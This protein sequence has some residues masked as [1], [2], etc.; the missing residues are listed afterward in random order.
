[1]VPYVIRN[2]RGGISD[3]NDRGIEGSFKHGHSLDIHGRDN[4]IRAASAVAT[5]LD[6]TTGETGAGSSTRGT[7]ITSHFNVFVPSYDG[8]TYAFG[9]TGSIMARSGDGFWTNVYNDTESITGA[10]EFGDSSGAIYMYWGKS[11]SI[12][13]RQMGGTF[14]TARDSGQ[15]RWSNATQV[16]KTEY[17]QST[18][19]WHTMSMASG[20]L[21]MANG[22][23][24]AVID[25][26]GNFNPLKLNIRPGNIINCLE[27]RDDNIILGSERLDESEEGH[28]WSWVVTALNWVQK[29]KIPVQGINALINT[30]DRLLQGGNNG[31]IFYSDFIN[32][33]PVATIP[34]GGKVI[35]SGVAIHE[36]LAAFGFSGGTYPGIWT[37][38]RRHKNRSPAFN[39]QYRLI[40][41]VNGSTVATIGAVAVINGTLLA[42]W[43]IN[44]TDSSS[45]GIDAVSATSRATALFEGLEFDKGGA[46]DKRMVK[47]AHAFF[48]PLVSGTS[49]SLKYKIDRE[50]AWRYV[51]FADGSTTFSI[52]N[53][54]E[55]IGSIGAPAHILEIGG[56]VNSSGSDTPEIHEIAIYLADES[57]A[58]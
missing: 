53:E 40:G 14:D 37:Y 26:D 29:K 46:W 50:S 23:G 18:A 9:A 44:E 30:E 39:Y 41:T 27:E 47:T 17:I 52:A 48:N 5:I 34:G 43:G 2:F 22:E 10:G 32:S 58:Y 6:S 19:A 13:R 57:N 56:E 25:F 24:L 54:T 49:F 3:E 20:A 33:I 38:G 36:D 15:A 12:A 42:S 7:T 31:E 45:Y 16:W 51:I 8:T 11:T 1:M 55:A 21:M 28:L 35:P 4:V